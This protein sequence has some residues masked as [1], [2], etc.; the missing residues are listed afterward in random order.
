MDIWKVAE[1]VEY[2]VLF[3]K[4]EELKEPVVEAKQCRVGQLEEK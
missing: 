1:D 2:I 4:S 3:S